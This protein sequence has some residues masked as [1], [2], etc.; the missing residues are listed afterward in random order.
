MSTEFRSEILEFLRTE[1]D[2]YHVKI[3]LAE[4]DNKEFRLNIVTA[5][6]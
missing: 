2:Y 4:L 1:R 5:E 3:F 6:I